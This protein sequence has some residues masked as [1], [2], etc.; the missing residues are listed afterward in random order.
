MLLAFAGAC[1]NRSRLE[2]V[3]TLTTSR[4][5][6]AGVDGRLGPTLDSIAK[7]AITRGVASGIAIAVGR[8]GRLIHLR[9]Y[10]TTDW[11]PGSDAVSDSSLFDI[12]SL[13]KVVATTTAAMMLEEDGRLDLDR[14][15]RLYVPELKARAKAAITSRML[16]THSAGFEAGA[17]LYRKSRGR[18]AY[19][20]QINLR[21][22]KYK[23]GTGS[24]YSDWDMV[25]AG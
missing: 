4:P 9:G 15:V 16:L 21:P 11:A 6:V 19:L 17:P 18:A 23:P 1:D 13:T 25:V 2:G 10:G 12:A 7:S 22:L 5:A 8:Y 24:M 14:P 3:D 20:R